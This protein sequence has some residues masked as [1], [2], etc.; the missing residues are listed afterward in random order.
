M[1]PAGTPSELPV[2]VDKRSGVPIYVQLAERIRLLIREGRLRAGDSLP[3]VRQLAVDLG[4]NANTVARVYREL[5][6]DGVLCL[7]RGLGTTVADTSAPAVPRADFQLIEK[8]VFE[9]IR[10]GREAGLRPAELSQLIET[11]WQERAP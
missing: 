4:V 10:L 7:E 9:L 2:S 5:Q 8:T 3:T 11:R 6:A 1:D